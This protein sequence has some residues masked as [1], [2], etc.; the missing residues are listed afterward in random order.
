MNKDDLGESLLLARLRTKSAEEIAKPKEEW[1]AEGYDAD[2]SRL[3]AKIF[4]AIEIA[5][6]EGQ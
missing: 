1:L 5:F 6:E 4:A 3:D 2:H